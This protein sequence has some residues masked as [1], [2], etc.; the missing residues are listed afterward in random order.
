[1]EA[2]CRDLGD[3]T[4]DPVERAALLEIADNYKRHS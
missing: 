3:A 1:M 4:P 2:I